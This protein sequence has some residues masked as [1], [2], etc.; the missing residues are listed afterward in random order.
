MTDVFP[1]EQLPVTSL[2][3]AIVAPAEDYLIS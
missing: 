2:F 3:S 1:A